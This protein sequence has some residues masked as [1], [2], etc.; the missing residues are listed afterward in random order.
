MPIHTEDRMKVWSA[1]TTVELRQK[2]IMYNMLDKSWEDEWVRGASEVPIPNINWSTSVSPASRNQ[3]GDWAATATLDQS[4]PTLKRSGGYSARNDIPWD[5][6]LEL[7]WPVISRVRSRQTWAMKN[8]IDKAVYDAM[9]TAAGQTVTG[10]TAGNTFVSR[11]SPYTATIATGRRHPVAEAIELFALA[12]TDAN[13]VD[14]DMSPTGMAGVPYVIIQPALGLSLAQWLE[15][16]GLQFDPLSM[17]MFNQNP[18]ALM[19]P[20]PLHMY[21]GCMIITW[22][23]LSVPA[24]SVDWQCYG[25]TM[26]AGACG[27]RP[28]IVQY[29]PP[30]LNQTSTGPAH[31]LRQIGD[32]AV[33]E[34]DDTL[35]RKIT[36]HSS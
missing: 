13:V 3:G 23:H 19:E 9:R 5:D 1:K 10:G 4:V 27:I 15:G 26:A 28:P 34:L 18:S 20:N 24:A 22:N 16:Q 29:F 36:V 25:G 21:R 2:S 35:H 8:S 11:A 17:A 30:E 6:V 14:G 12:M 32:Y 33:V 7:P 31:L